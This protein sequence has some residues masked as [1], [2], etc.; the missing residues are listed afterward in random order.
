M[1]IFVLSI[2]KINQNIEEEMSDS[3][4]IKK[5]KIKKEKVDF[6]PIACIKSHSSHAPTKNFLFNCDTLICNLFNYNVNFIYY[7]VNFLC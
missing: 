7:K 4:S 3:G 2:D 6:C 5:R 1:A